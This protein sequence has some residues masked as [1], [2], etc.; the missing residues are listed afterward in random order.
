MWAFFPK[1]YFPRQHT[2]VP[3]PHWCKDTEEMNIGLMECH[4][5]LLVSREAPLLLVLTEV[6]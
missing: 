6:D 2:N 5:I 1:E 4:V 3:P